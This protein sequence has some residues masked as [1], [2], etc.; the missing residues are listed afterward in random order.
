LSRQHENDKID[1]F[2]YCLCVFCSSSDAVPHTFLKLA[3]NLAKQMIEKKWGL[4]FGGGNVG[5]MGSL[6]RYIKA[7]GGYIIGV[8]TER[9][10]RFGVEQQNID[11]MIVTKTMRERK[12]IMEEKSDAFVILPGGFGTLEE[13]SEVITLKELGEHDKPIVILNHEGFFDSLIM[14]YEE[15][16]KLQFAKPEFRDLYHISPTIE[17]AMYYL[18]NYKAQTI[19]VKWFG[20]YQKK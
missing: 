3:E 4:V 13:L 10:L 6:S 12:A 1:K 9:I 8:I 17:D 2:L 5:L 7:N 14:F 18:S 11:K 20:N 19:P 16:Y 15:M